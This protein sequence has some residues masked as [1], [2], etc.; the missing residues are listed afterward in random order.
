MKK[1]FLVIIIIFTLISTCNI[2]FAWVDYPVSPNDSYEN[3]NNQIILKMSQIDNCSFLVFDDLGSYDG[4]Y[5]S[6][7]EYGD[8]NTVEKNDIILVTFTSNYDVFIEDN[9]VWCI[10]EN[11]NYGNV[12]F[13]IYVT[14]YGWQLLYSPDF[15]TYVFDGLRVKSNWE[16][17]GDV[18]ELNCTIWDGYGGIGEDS[19]LNG[20]LFSSDFG[21]ISFGYPYNGF[22]DNSWLFSF[23]VNYRVVLGEDEKL[24]DYLVKIY[25]LDSEMQVVEDDD[26]YRDV[27]SHRVYKQSGNIYDMSLLFN[28]EMLYGDNYV[29][30]NVINPDGNTIARKTVKVI[31]L[32][33]FIDEDEDGLDDRTGQPFVPEKPVGPGTGSGPGID[34]PEKPGEDGNAI[35]WLKYLG[36]YVGYI[37]QV[38][39]TSIG[40]FAK[41]V[42]SGV[43]SVL[44]LADPMFSFISQFFSSM[45][46]EIKTA[47]LAMFSVSVFLVIMKMIRG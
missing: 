15:N 44:S 18:Q 2:C 41:N 30:V 7:L 26:L 43:G 36:E 28:M 23:G 40:N 21:D 24:S 4:Y 39:I 34:V 29:E 9:K 11:D 16:F 13:Y 32:E 27:Y 22:A 42:V 17:K 1:I 8:G 31:R 10:D 25:H 12:Q 3:Y 38:L 45:P 35:D 46:I 37:F 20:H 33:G 5:F 6:F 19:F 14:G 47:I